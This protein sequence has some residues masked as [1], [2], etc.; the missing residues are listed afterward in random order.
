VSLILPHMCVI[1][2]ELYKISI[3]DMHV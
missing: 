1:I 3:S 2:S